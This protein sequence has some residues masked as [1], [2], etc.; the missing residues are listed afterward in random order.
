MDYITALFKQTP[1]KEVC[2]E[3]K[4]TELIE[5]EKKI[6]L[7]TLDNETIPSDKTDFLFDEKYGIITEDVLCNII[8]ESRKQTYEKINMEKLTEKVKD[9]IIFGIKST[10][11]HKFMRMIID[12]RIGTVEDELG[13]TVN[14]LSETSIRMGKNGDRQT[15]TLLVFIV[16]NV[17]MH[18]IVT[19]IISKNICVVH[20]IKK[21]DPN[22]FF[23]YGDEPKY[24]LL[25]LTY[26][27]I[28]QAGTT[29]IKLLETE[30]NINYI[31]KELL[32]I[33]KCLIERAMIG[34]TYY[35]VET[36][37]A[38]FIYS[39]IKQYNLLKVKYEL[40][41]SNILSFSW[42]KQK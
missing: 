20:M 16:N 18:K 17:F 4:L 1:K 22:E 32:D 9:E 39:Y 3:S 37:Y 6:D 7:N 5:C 41:N 36:K 23:W 13:S 26:E 38:E 15:G 8:D 12:V 2:D 31:K 25:H 35:E 42:D 30:E 29:I 10:V 40:K 19:N 24:T 34:S 14:K 11:F 27:K 21:K 33:Q 28:L